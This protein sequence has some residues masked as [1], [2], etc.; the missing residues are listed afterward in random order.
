M[1]HIGTIKASDI[2]KLKS[3]AQRV[4]PQYCHTWLVDVLE[5][6]EGKGLINSGT[7]VTYRANV[8]QQQ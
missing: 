5:D 4:T 3:S 8:G 2:N 6:I 7:A 1:E